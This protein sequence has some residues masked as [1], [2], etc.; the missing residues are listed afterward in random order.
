[1]SVQKLGGTAVVMD[2]YDPE[3]ALPLIE[4]HRVTHAQFAPTHFLRMLKLPEDT[5]RAAAPRR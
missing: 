2:K 4:R 5:R 3:Q 1:M